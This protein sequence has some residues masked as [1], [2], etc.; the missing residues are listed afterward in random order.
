MKLSII[1]PVYNVE[2][3]IV[4]CLESIY[5]QD[6][7]TNDYEVIIIDDGTKDKSMELIKEFSKKYNN[8][9][10]H[11]QENKGLANARNKGI[12]LAKGDYI[13]FLDSDDYIKGGVLSTIMSTIDL[14]DLDVLTFNSKSINYSDILDSLEITQN[15]NFNVNVETGVEYISGRSY[16][17]EV[18]WYVVKKSFL[19][20]LNISFSEGTY[21]EDGIFTANVLLNAK[22]IAHIPLDMHRYV[23]RPQSIMSKKTPR[24][25]HKMAVDMVNVAITFKPLLDSLEPTSEM[26]V[27]A[28]NRLKVRQESYVFFG[29][30]RMLSSNIRL[31]EVKL[32]LN[33]VRKAKAYPLTVFAGHEYSG[34]TYKALSFVFSKKKLFCLVFRIANPVLRKRAS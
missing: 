30:L 33:E 7:S 8:I 21:V 12:G 25:Y 14:Y 9:I 23:Q 32:I 4:K 20:D 16:K 31:K 3:Y 18:W 1:L 17:N 10:V 28:Y 6:V 34:A 29:L 13:Y 27:K 19:E 11:H 24:H 2:K 26:Q 15:K 22:R 5:F